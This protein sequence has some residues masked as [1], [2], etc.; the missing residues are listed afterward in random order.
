MT[1]TTDSKPVK[2]AKDKLDPVIR[3]LADNMRQNMTMEVDGKEATAVVSKDWFVNTLPD[4]LTQQVLEQAAQHHANALIASNLALSEAAIDACAEN[5]E[6]HHVTLQ[7]PT[8]G[9]DHFAIDFTRSQQVGKHTVHGVTRA[10]HEVYGAQTGSGQMRVVKDI[11]SDR[12]R[13]VLSKL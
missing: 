12:A 8:V 13:E 11:I 6:L 9:K 10:S 5:K 7:V 2:T 4:G 1:I 3:Q